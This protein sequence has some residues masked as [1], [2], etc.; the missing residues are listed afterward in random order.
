MNKQ[1]RFDYAF[2]MLALTGCVAVFFST[3][4]AVW[5]FACASGIAIGGMIHLSYVDDDLKED[6]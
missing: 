5:M 1:T 4:L 3:V 6:G 2:W